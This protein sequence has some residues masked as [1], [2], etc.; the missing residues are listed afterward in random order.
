MGTFRID[1]TIA[2]TGKR[3][4]TAPITKVMVDT[5]SELTWLPEATLREIGIE[6]RKKDQPFV[7]ANGQRITRDVGYAV[8]RCGQFET[9]DEVVFAKTGDYSLLGARTIEGFNAHIDTVK[10]RLVAVGGIPAAG[11]LRI[12]RKDVPR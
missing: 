5:G 12:H 11:N 2:G 8:I 6:V 10:K 1:L 4:R 9:I 3:A 7:M